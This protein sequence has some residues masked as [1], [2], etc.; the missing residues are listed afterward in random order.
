[1]RKWN[2]IA[3]TVV[4]TLALLIPLGGCGSDS[5]DTVATTAKVENPEQVFKD[6]LQ[7]AA[8]K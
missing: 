5:K 8:D 2:S 3:A 4:T 7:K 6:I 1:M